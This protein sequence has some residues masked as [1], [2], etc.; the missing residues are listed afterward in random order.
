MQDIQ[1]AP[2]TKS[3]AAVGRKKIS[4]PQL[5]LHALFLIGT[6]IIVL[7]IILVLSVSFS[8]ESSIFISGYSFL[9]EKFSLSAYTFLWHD[10]ANILHAYGITVSVTLIGAVCGLLMIALRNNFV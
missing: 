7:P 10:R 6:F 2:S 4:I 8:D 9:P 1:L 3:H 5:L